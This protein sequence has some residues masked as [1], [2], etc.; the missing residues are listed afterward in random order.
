MAKKLTVIG[1]TAVAFIASVIGACEVKVHGY[2]AAFSEVAVGDTESSV[3]GRFGEPPVWETAA[4]PYLRY[5][6]SPCTKPCAVRLWWEMPI[7]PGIEAWSVE[8]GQ[9]R[10]V[11]HTAHWVSP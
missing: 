5:A 7:I 8:L 3:V 4:Q 9:D 10:D 2:N 6:A 1:V 11:V